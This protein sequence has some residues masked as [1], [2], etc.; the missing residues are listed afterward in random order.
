MNLQEIIFERMQA[1]FSPT[2]CEV[3]DDSARHA[4][5]AGARDG[6]K[7]YILKI[8]AACFSERSRVAVHRE[9]YQVLQDLMPHKIHA[10]Q[11]QILS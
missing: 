8:K 7:H 1:K 4:G 2:F 11:I 9:I 6:G 5:H 10:L 3:I